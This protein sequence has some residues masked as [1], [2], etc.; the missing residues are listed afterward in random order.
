MMHAA[1]AVLGLSFM[2]CALLVS[3]LPPLPGFVGKFALLSAV[4][5]AHGAGPAAWT[6][7][8]LVMLSG[9]ASL[10][11][12]ARAGIRIFWATEWRTLP[13]VRVIEIAP[14]GLLLSLLV[15]LTV[16]AG[17]AMSYFQ[18]A[19]HELAARS[20]YMEAVLGRP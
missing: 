16:A 18:R 2:G 17:P 11:A 14:V 19:A 15:A 4:L 5:G 6:L 9:L 10:I 1:M 20:G 7:L 13:R 12:L 8:A 3:G